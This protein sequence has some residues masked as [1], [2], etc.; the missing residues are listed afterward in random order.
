MEPEGLLAAL[1]FVSQAGEGTVLHSS[2][3]LALLS[4]RYTS[5]GALARLEVERRPRDDFYRFAVPYRLSNVGLQ[6]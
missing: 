3:N 6:T 5:K 1:H 2:D 4:C